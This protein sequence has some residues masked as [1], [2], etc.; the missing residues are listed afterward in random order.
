MNK[1]AMYI[2]KIAPSGPSHAPTRLTRFSVIER[3]YISIS[4]SSKHL[5]RFTFDFF[6]FA[7][8]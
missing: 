5:K 8:N 7:S 6:N 1:V 4:L 3:K 2:R